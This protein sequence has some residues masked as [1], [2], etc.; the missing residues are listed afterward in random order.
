[1]A[2]SYTALLGLALPVTGELQGTWGDTVN[3]SI[4]QLCED[5]IAGAATQSVLS[6][7]WTLTTTGLGA[8]NQARMA[9]LIP[10]GAPGVS[11]NIIAPSKSKIYTVIN[12]SNA[13]VVIKGAATTGVTIAAGD[14]VTVVWNGSDF[15]NIV[16]T[17]APGTFTN[18]AY[19]GTLTGGT[20]IVN[21]GS[22][23]IYKD[24]AG[25][26]GIGKV[27]SV[28][29][30]VNG[31]V[32]TG[33]IQTGNGVSTGAA[34]IELGGA[35]TGSG[36]SFIDF[37]STSGTDNEARIARNSGANGTFD[38]ANTGTGALQIYQTSAAPII[39]SVSLVEKA[40]FDS[41]GY[42]L[43]GTTTASGTNL[44]QVN[45]D[46]L[47]NGLT[48][49][50][51]L[52]SVVT[53]TAF[54]VTALSAV[55]TGTNNTAFGYQA[56][57]LNDTGAQ[58]IAFGG[59]ALGNNT[60]GN[61][62]TAVGLNVLV[63]NTTGSGNS[64]LGLQALSSNTTGASN[65]A[66]GFYSL[67]Q[68]TIGGSNNGY[69]RFSL[70]SA[71]S[72]VATLGTITGG[73][74]YTNG[75]YTGVVMTLSSGST[76]FTYPTAT[77]VVSGGAVTTV[78]I[79]SP[80]SAFKDTTTVLTAPAASIGGTG[81]GFSVPVAT[82]TTA[83]NNTAVGDLAL[84]FLYNGNNNTAVGFNTGGVLTNASQNTFIGYQAGASVTTGSNNVIIGN[85]A[86]AA[87]PISATGSNYIVLADGAANIR[88]V[89]DSSGNVGIG[90][91]AP[92]QK[93]Q[94]TGGNI[95]TSGGQLITN[96]ANAAADTTAGLVLQIDATTHAQITTPAS[97]VMA[98]YTGGTERMRI[99][100]SGNVG[101]GLT[102]VGTKLDVSGVTRSTTFSVGASGGTAA[103]GAG[104]ISTDANWGMY[105]RANTG[106]A[107]AEFVF[108]NGAG[109]ERMRIESTVGQMQITSTGTPLLADS[110]FAGLSSIGSRNSNASG[111]PGVSINSN[112]A[113]TTAKSTG[114]IHFD[115]LTTGSTYT[116]FSSIYS[117]SGT[118]T[119]TGAPTSLV[120]NTS[121]GTANAV[122]RMRI[123]PS[124][125]VGVGTSGPSSKLTVLSGTNNGI[126]V[127]DGTVTSIFFNTSSSVGSL[128]TQSNHPF[129]FWANNAERMRIDS[130]GNVG[131]GTS[132]PSTKLHVVG[133]ITQNATIASWNAPISVYQNN[134]ASFWNNGPS[135]V[136]GHNVVFGTSYATTRIGAGY[137]TTIGLSLDGLGS[138]DFSVAGTD[139]AGSTPSFTN[140]MRITSAGRIGMGSTSPAVKLEVSSTDAI[141]IPKGTT[142][143]RPT[144]VSGYVRF[145]S[146]LGQ[147]E[148]YNGTAWGALGGGAT[149]G[150]ANQ[151]FYE[152]GQ[153]VSVN[154]TITSGKSAMSTGPITINSGITVT[155]P[156][157]S[158][159]VVL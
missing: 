102:T 68:N 87:A 38:I 84:R 42:L 132:T 79:T 156:S 17:S 47:I 111:I 155:I 86:G 69:G 145:N 157:G 40:R 130:S 8:A 29:L 18:L 121:D 72:S 36:I 128:G 98:M 97:S 50:K 6:A 104:T 127:S 138:I 140:A 16:T 19:T 135:T 7:D 71:T 113:W 80:G 100:S 73:S 106:A 49:G 81:S 93:L 77:I 85:Y 41:S 114:Q 116:V 126:T 45:S 119:T 23:Q 149:G 14:K 82:L 141:L 146:D 57:R 142:A 148:G 51:G 78:T 24:A 46:A 107:S 150:G 103:F 124:G 12:N 133:N 75:T 31:F 120:I 67:N 32:N 117:I 108:V 76:A 134:V 137:A 4:T 95:Y 131:I 65:N 28:L 10:T 154:Y 25:N 56:L 54:G 11:R 39:F 55:T 60:S 153:T 89:I 125:N 20:G 66:Y 33:N 115:G 92:S 70:Q 34:S 151:V 22:N 144:G 91:T 74:G 129:T 105:F 90:T 101:I 96:R 59:G 52:G 99:D 147:Y 9:I 15:V 48:V 58:N 13:N 94:V 53:N 5:S 159:W 2:T 44:L 88:Q 3:N 112:V 21:I 152:N 43:V 122:E 158:R 62:N 37:H 118:N 26:V 110:S 83:N 30:D 143:Q 1:M 61:Y 64:G 35:R 139:V 136:I 27:P 109:T 123:D 63:A